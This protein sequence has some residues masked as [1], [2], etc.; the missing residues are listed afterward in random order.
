MNLSKE[1]ICLKKAYTKPQFLVE[2]F[3]L[4]QQ[5]AKCNAVRISFEDRGCVFRDSDSTPEMKRLAAFGVFMGGCDL[6]PESMGKDTMCYF[7]NMH[8]VFSS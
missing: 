4:T 6:V 3:A 8:I 7:S 5:I 1:M 2:N